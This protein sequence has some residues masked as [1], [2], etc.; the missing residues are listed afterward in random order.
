MLLAV[1]IERG[2]DGQRIKIVFEI[3]F[4]LPAVGVQ[5]LAEIAELIEE[6]YADEGEIVIARRFQVVAGK[7]PRPPE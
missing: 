2:L 4:L 3:A 6:P 7:M 5:I 1:R